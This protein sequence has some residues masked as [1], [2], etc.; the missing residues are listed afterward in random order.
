MRGRP[1]PRRI[2]PPGRMPMTPTGKAP[3]QERSSGFDQGGGFFGRADGDAQVVADGGVTEPA[4]E[5]LAVAQFLEPGPG[6]E[7]RRAH[8]DEIG[9]AREDPEAEG[10]KL[11]AQPLAGGDDLPEVG[12]VAGQ[13]VQCRQRRDLAQAVD[14]VAVADLVERGDEVRVAD[15]NSRRAGSKANRPSRRSARP[16]RAGISARAPGRSRGRNPRR[17]R[18]G[19][20]TPF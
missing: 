6:G 5:D 20:T 16:A 12:P 1:C 11:P 17:P 19:R 2:I 7:S 15:D 14:V 9:L 18:P 3:L 13:V 8:E 4:H 10:L